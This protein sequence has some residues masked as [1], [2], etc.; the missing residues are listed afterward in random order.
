LRLLKI[1]AA[2]VGGSAKN[3]PLETAGKNLKAINTT[4]QN[5]FLLKL[6]SSLNHNLQ[7]ATE[8]TKNNYRY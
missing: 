3:C 7:P 2:D 8:T 6:G 4:L 1:D 5:T